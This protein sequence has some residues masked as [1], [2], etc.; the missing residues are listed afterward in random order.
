MSSAALDCEQWVKAPSQGQGSPGE[1]IHAAV[2][3]LK[4]VPHWRI[5][6]AFYG[7]AGSW[8]V[9]AYLQL[10]DAYDRWEAK[11]HDRLSAETRAAIEALSV[12][13]ERLSQTD[14]ELHQVHIAALDV[15][16]ERL[17]RGDQD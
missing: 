8:G 13:R 9:A 7:N 3:A 11:Q 14:P 15:A 1:Q 2:K 16:I 10:R 6:D 12:Q 4:G 5:R 17:S